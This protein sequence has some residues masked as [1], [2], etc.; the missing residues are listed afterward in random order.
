MNTRSFDIETVT[1][2][3]CG[4]WIQ[5]Q[6]VTLDETMEDGGVIETLMVSGKGIGITQCQ[7]RSFHGMVCGP[8]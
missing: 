6:A 3:D 1:C 4:E 7:G 8:R 2:D 5:V